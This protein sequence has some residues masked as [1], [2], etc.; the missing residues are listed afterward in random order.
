MAPQ[1]IIALVLGDLNVAPLLAPPV[2]S[3]ANSPWAH[4][5]QP[6]YDWISFTLPLGDPL[7]AG[8]DP[9]RFPAGKFDYTA[10]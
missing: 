9:P 6:A 2:R 4:Y 5:R 8:G 7:K 3:D 1:T 10:T